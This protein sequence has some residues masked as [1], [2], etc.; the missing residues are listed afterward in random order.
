MILEAA[1]IGL[2]LYSLNL[3]PPIRLPRPELLEYWLQ[4][5]KLNTL[6]TNEDTQINTVE[7]VNNYVTDYGIKDD[8]LGSV[9]FWDSNA[10]LIRRLER[11]F[12]SKNF[13]IPPSED[14]AIRVTSRGTGANKNYD[15]VVHPT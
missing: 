14:L 6:I 1:F 15:P 8:G 5:I 3:L 13:P 9:T 4:P 11:D 2:L 10:A 7:G 12:D